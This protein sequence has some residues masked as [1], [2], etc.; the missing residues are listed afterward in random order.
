MGWSHSFDRTIQPSHQTSP[1]DVM[2]FREDGSKL[3]FT[4]SGGNWVSTSPTTKLVVRAEIKA[5]R[6]NEPSSGSANALHC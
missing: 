5:K 2:V 3:K 6:R 1:T 4:L